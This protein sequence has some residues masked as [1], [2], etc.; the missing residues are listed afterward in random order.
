MRS[1]SEEWLG[2]LRGKATVVL[3]DIPHYSLS[4]QLLLPG[5]IRKANIDL[6]FSPHFNV[7]LR[8]PVPFVVTIHDLILYRFPNAASFLKKIAFKAIMRHSVTK[9]LRI[10][11]VSTFTKNELCEMYGSLL[12]NKISAIHEGI[13]THFVP[14]S[15]RSI[16]TVRTRYGLPNTYFLYVGNAK[17]HKNVQLL[18]N[19]FS[20]ATIRNSELILL[21][22]GKEI[23][24]LIL[25]EGV[26]VISDV[27][28]KDLPALYSGAR[29]F[30]TASLYEGFCFP[31]LESAACGCPV[32]ATNGSAIAEVAPAGSL[33]IEPQEELFAAALRNPPDPPDISFGIPSWERA[34]EE[35]LA[36]FRE[37][38]SLL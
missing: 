30:V 29:A 14:A 37:A 20:S 7:P 25:S 5:I 6:F 36:V 38:L 28:E 3:A 19:A 1:H 24:T 23:T 2:E 17:E 31:V 12:Q 21:S 11:S 32:I 34:A 8:C 15:A 26:R 27:E 10:I 22:A 16:S 33:L 18:I 13:D 9:A 4:E 35:T